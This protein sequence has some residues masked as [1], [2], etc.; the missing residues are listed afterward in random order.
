MAGIARKP[1]LV[2]DTDYLVEKI[3]HL[4]LYFGPFEAFIVPE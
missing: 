2:H 3:Y 4:S 1:A